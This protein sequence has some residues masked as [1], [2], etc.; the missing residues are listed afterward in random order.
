MSIGDKSASMLRAT[1][2]GVPTQ[3]QQQVLDVLPS[4]WYSS[5]T[6]TTTPSTPQ[7]AANIL[8]KDLFNSGYSIDVPPMGHCGMK[9][10][11]SDPLPVKM[12]LKFVKFIDLDEK[13]SVL[14][15][16]V[17]LSVMWP[18]E[19]LD[20][21]PTAHAFLGPWDHEEDSIPIE[22]SKLWMPDIQLA[23]AAA[24]TESISMIDAPKAFVYS[25]EKRRREGF[26]VRTR[27]PAV[28]HVKCELNLENFPF[29]NQSCKF[30]FRPWT[31]NTKRMNLLPA[32]GDQFEVSELSGKNEE[33]SILKISE[34]LTRFDQD[35]LGD[36]AEHFAQVE[37]TLYFQRHV[38][39]Y[40][41]RIVLP[42]LMVVVLSA[43]LFYMK[44][45]DARVI[46]G[47]TLVLVVMSVSS[48]SASLLPKAG[49]ADTWL[50]RF[51]SNCYVAVMTPLFASL[52]LILLERI[53]VEE[54]NLKHVASVRSARVLVVADKCLR[55]LFVLY[56]LWLTCRMLLTPAI[57]E[58]SETS[59]FWVKLYLTLVIALMVLLA[60]LDVCL[61]VMDRR[62]QR[63]GAKGQVC[64]TKSA[65]SQEGFKPRSIDHQR[66]LGEPADT[67]A[68]AR[69]L[70]EQTEAEAL[71][72]LAEAMADVEVSA[73]SEDSN[74]DGASDS[75][76]KFEAAS[77]RASLPV[78]KGHV[79]RLREGYPSP[80]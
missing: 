24:P 26:N 12:G 5:P 14:T 64:A 25:K 11:C 71:A 17:I 56:V 68:E 52:F 40:L 62:Q 72:E 76:E 61:L 22:A 54:H 21:D 39:F 77:S 66:S 7:S 2:R 53:L 48:F 13:S 36:G 57:W 31:S 16:Q 43:G 78:H 80:Q 67:D 49:G 8:Y 30:V 35:E 70:A 65:S 79:R 27:Q 63:E 59:V 10:E 38:H 29:D 69:A 46:V 28:M 51:Q 37:Y 19:R 75:D 74:Q 55:L 60:L 23:N 20:Y 45:G 47:V 58:S 42:M 15:V 18:D 34:E 9:P 1:S 33:F 32:S 44:L 73:E 4:W 6:T 50:E 41:A 3:E